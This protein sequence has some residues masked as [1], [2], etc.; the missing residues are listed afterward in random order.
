MKA[1]KRKGPIAEID[2][3][4]DSSKNLWRLIDSGMSSNKIY[5][6]PSYSRFTKTNN[7]KGVPHPLSG[8]Y[9]PKPQEEIDDSLYV[10]VKD[11]VENTFE[12]SFETESESLSEPNEM[13]KSRLEVTNEKDV[14]APKSKEVE[15]SCV[16]HIKTPRQ[17]LK[18]KETH[19]V[20]RK[21][22]NDMMERELGE[23]YSFTKKKCFVCGSLNHL[24]KDC[25]YYEKKMARED[26]VK[27][28]VNTSNRVAKPVWTNANR[29]N[30]AN[31]FVTR[32]VQLNASR[33]KLNSVRPNINTAQMA[34][35]N[36]V[37][38]SWGSAVKTSASYNWRNNRP[39]FHYNSGPTFN[40][41][42]NAN[43]PQGRPK[44][45]KAWVTR[46]NWRIL[47]NSMGDLL[48]LEVAKATY[49]DAYDNQILYK[50]LDT[51]TCYL[52]SYKAVLKQQFKR[53]SFYQEQE[54]EKQE[55]NQIGLLTMDDGI[56]NWG[57]H[58]EVEETNHAL[59]AISSS[60]E[61]SLCSKICIDSYNTLKTLCDEQMNQLGDQEAQILGDPKSAVQ[62]RSKE[63]PKK[64]SE[65]LQDHSW[66]QAMQE[67]LLQFKLQQ[68]WVLVDL[69]HGMKVIGTKWV[70]RNKRDERGV[71]VR[72]KARLVAQGYTQEVVLL[73][74]GK[75][76]NDNC[77]AKEFT[78]RNSSPFPDFTLCIQPNKTRNS[79]KPVD[80]TSHTQKPDRKIVT[81]HSFSPNKSSAVHEKTNTP[82]SYLSGTDRVEFLTLLVLSGFHWKE[83]SH[84]GTAKRMIDEL[85]NGS[86]DY[87]T[88]SY[89]CDQTLNV[90]AGTLNLSAG[91]LLKEKKS[92]RFSALFLQ[93]KRNLLVNA[94]IGTNDLGVAV[95]SNCALRISGLYT[96]RC[97]M[98]TLQESSES[99]LNDQNKMELSALHPAAENPVKK[100]LLKLNLSVSQ[101]D[102]SGF[103]GNRFDGETNETLLK[104]MVQGME[105]QS[106][107]SL[108]VIA[109]LHHVSGNRSRR[110]WV[111]V[112]I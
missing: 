36:A 103:E 72:N 102:S 109:D 82:R 40:R 25:D 41:T 86:I 75:L 89:K 62:T 43:G 45:A 2:S 4:K 17:P 95:S 94:L 34:H 66:V 68:V 96:S 5:G 97:L 100:I 21:N 51:T 90:S 77:Y 46:I 47:K 73:V 13:S 30:H 19:K 76:P 11:L 101:V 10:Y 93:K 74:R 32:S 14:S 29:V 92:V 53:D 28:V 88:N 9:T 31:Q 69:S 79:N 12:H 98:R 63:E 57:E 105:C 55:K 39:N 22:W 58:T 84:L 56:V 111:L 26:E 81:G 35:S 3:W 99:L 67:E 104:E 110:L 42:V 85:P 7:F 16:S 91:P 87:I 18:D 71:V 23:G 108:T 80:P 59:M 33:P 54:A 70:Y 48:P 78:R 83:H 65:A 6:I 27:R 106:L 61:V 8:D 107:S 44:P 64:I 52:S 20:N 15:P 49:L 37:M 24:I 112:W 1:V 60:N 50:A 38:E